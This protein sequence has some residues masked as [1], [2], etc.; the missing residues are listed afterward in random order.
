MASGALFRVGADVACSSGLGDGFFVRRRA[1]VVGLAP[2]KVP[3]GRD[4]DDG[5]EDH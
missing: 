4:D 3:H 2:D 1:L 5:G